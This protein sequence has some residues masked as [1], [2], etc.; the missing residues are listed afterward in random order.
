MASRLNWE[1]PFWGTVS[2]AGWDMQASNDGITAVLADTYVYDEMGHRVE[3]VEGPLWIERVVGQARL[4][5]VFADLAGGVSG[6]DFHHR[7]YPVST[8]DLDVFDRDI[9][10]QGEA[11]SDFMWH[12]VEYADLNTIENGASAFG[13]DW[14]LFNGTHAQKPFA[15]GRN[16]YFDVKVGRYLREGEALVYKVKGATIPNGGSWTAQWDSGGS[17][18]CAL[19]LWVRVLLRRHV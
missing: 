8:D 11:D 1:A 4:R 6:V 5:F 16:G 18:F 17:S 19:D 14:L 9:Q 3:Q 7:I 12:K 2:S 13:G 15:D 10:S